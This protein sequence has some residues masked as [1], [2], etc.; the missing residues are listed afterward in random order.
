MHHNGHTTEDGHGTPGNVVHTEDRNSTSMDNSHNQPD[1]R[2]CQELNNSGAVCDGVHINPP[3][4]NPDCVVKYQSTSGIHTTVSGFDTNNENVMACPSSLSENENT[5]SNSDSIDP[6]KGTSP[7][8]S[9]TIHLPAFMT[10]AVGTS[11]VSTIDNNTDNSTMALQQANPATNCNILNPSLK[12]P[13]IHC[14]TFTARSTEPELLPSALMVEHGETGEECDI[15]LSEFGSAA[16]TPNPTS[17]TTSQGPATAARLASTY[18]KTKSNR[19]NLKLPIEYRSRFMTPYDLYIGHLLDITNHLNPKDCAVASHDAIQT[20]PKG[21]KWT[22]WIGEELRTRFVDCKQRLLPTGTHGQ[23]IALLLALKEEHTRRTRS[24]GHAFDHGH[25]QQHQSLTHSPDQ[26]SGFRPQALQQASPQRTY[27]FGQSPT[28]S[29]PH[30]PPPHLQQKPIHHVSNQHLSRRPSSVYSG[31]PQPSA[32]VHP[33]HWR[34]QPSHNPHH[35]Q[36]A[37]PYQQHGR[38]N[39]PQR[40][41]SASGDVYGMGH[42][43]DY[44]QHHAPPQ[45]MNANYRIPMGSP[46]SQS[47]NL[48]AY[49]FSRG[50]SAGNANHIR[51]ASQGGYRMY[52]TSMGGGGHM[53]ENQV[54]TSPLSVSFHRRINHDRMNSYPNEYHPNR[55]MDT[56]RSHDQMND[57][58][59]SQ[60]VH[61]INYRSEAGL[62]AKRPAHASY[63]NESNLMPLNHSPMPSIKQSPSQYSSPYLYHDQPRAPHSWQEQAH[64]ERPEKKIDIRGIGETPEN[65][66]DHSSPRYAAS[67]L[68]QNSNVDLDLS[69]ASHRA[70]LANSHRGSSPL[71]TTPVL[72]QEEHQLKQSKEHS[73]AL[74]DD[75]SN[76]LSSA[77]EHAAM[78][79]LTD[80]DAKTKSRVSKDSPG[81][82]TSQSTLPRNQTQ[83]TSRRFS[84]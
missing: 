48:P 38:P 74:V 28:Q 63:A 27:S 53:S 84:F 60:S 12:L 3:Q 80:A 7:V 22:V 40:P 46:S 16:T 32:L 30:T 44:Y 5:L 71:A 37:L 73:S 75:K 24:Q 65:G 62:E 61:P 33:E 4:S 82:W 66:F 1:T 15:S 39:P 23:F 9:R 17:T 68:R 59:G 14:P 2:I 54:T 13:A 77:N 29:Y 50:L 52:P 76:V 21:S 26:T 49:N 70:A 69:N 11:K 20:A 47:A 34:H 8:L 72:R 19:H 6:T 67:N 10:V 58:S 42:H 41:A 56:K 51:T 35:P 43:S 64:N 45:N 79:D 18:A 78:A 81:L 55:M 36:Y 83:Y 57:I 31:S 25:P